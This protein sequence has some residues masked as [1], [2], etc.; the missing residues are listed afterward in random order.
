M[1][2]SFIL[3]ASLAQSN[4][5]IKIKE[6]PLFS[7]ILLLGKCVLAQM[8]LE[9]LLCED[10]IQGR[11]SKNRFLSGLPRGREPELDAAELCVL[12]APLLTASPLEVGQLLA[13]WHEGSIPT[14]CFW[15]LTQAGCTE[16]FGAD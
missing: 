1:K 5:H 9:H 16:T 6:F 3:G 13:P 14:L 12:A 4:R 8:A 11:K 2:C 10:Q 7:F 15:P